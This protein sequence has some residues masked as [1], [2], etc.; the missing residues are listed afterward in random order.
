MLQPQAGSCTCI[1]IFISLYHRVVLV[2][3]L[4]PQA[5]STSAPWVSDS[6]PPVGNLWNKIK[7]PAADD[8]A[9]QALCKTWL[10]EEYLLVVVGYATTVARLLWYR[11]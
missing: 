6:L 7:A 2:L 1:F 5:G 4:P 10:R 11:Y 8:G 9:H 3:L